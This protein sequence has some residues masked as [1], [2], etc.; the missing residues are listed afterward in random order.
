MLDQETPSGL[1]GPGYGWFT[2]LSWFSW[3]VF[4]NCY[5]KAH[6]SSGKYEVFYEPLDAFDPKSH[7]SLS[8][9]SDKPSK[10]EVEL[11]KFGL[12]ENI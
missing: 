11:L 7:F 9:Y 3:F 12:K 2:S 10:Y 8:L 6:F 4:M 1:T 5:L